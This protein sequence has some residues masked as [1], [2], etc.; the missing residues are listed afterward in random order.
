MTWNI[1]SE[2]NQITEIIEASKLKP[3]L[4][5][6]HSTRCSISTMALNRFEKSG[7]LDNEQLDCWYLDLLE[8]RQISSEI[9][10]LTKVIHQSP[11]A[12]VVNNEQVIY[13][14]SH[15]MIDS[16]DILNIV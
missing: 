6:K 16:S 7:I 4:F 12:I 5:F 1:L 10:K 2:P 13:A 9:E 8:F 11:Q 15:G 14:E 3:Q